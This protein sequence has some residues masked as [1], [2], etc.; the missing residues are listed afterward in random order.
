LKDQAKADFL[1]DVQVFSQNYHSG[2]VELVDASK[3]ILS[4]E[5]ISQLSR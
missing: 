3:K 1:N 4:R 5:Q 2:T